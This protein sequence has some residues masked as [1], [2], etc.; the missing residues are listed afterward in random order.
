MMF[1]FDVKGFLNWGLNYWQPLRK[2]KNPA[3]RNW[4]KQPWILV[5][6]VDYD[7]AGDG[8][9]CYPGPDQ[10]P[11]ASLRL[12]NLRDGIEDYELMYLA[13]QKKKPVINKLTEIVRSKEN[14]VSSP[15]ELEA[16]RINILQSFEN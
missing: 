2:E 8:F 12:V 11:C 1:R 4:P 16:F 9:L 5:D 14:Y 7:R 10:K 13:R 3:I 6:N 15:A